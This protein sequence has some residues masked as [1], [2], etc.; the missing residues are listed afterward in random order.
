M[1]IGIKKETQLYLPI[2]AFFEELGYKVNAE[3]KDCDVVATKDDKVLIIELK[4]NFNISLLYQALDRQK[5]SGNVYIAIF[6]PKKD[7]ILKKSVY[8]AEKLGLGFIAVDF[9]REFMPVE[10]LACPN[11]DSKID[12]KRTSSLLKEIDQRFFEVNIAGVSG[13]VKKMTAYKEKAIKI[14]CA[15]D[16]A[17]ESSPKHLICSYKCSKDTQKILNSD[18][19]NW[20]DK[21]K[22]GVYCLSNNGKNFL[23]G[24]EYSDIINFYKDKIRG[25]D[26]V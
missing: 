3:V 22:R 19:Y 16:L 2:K 15:L 12:K 20:F 24:K 8:I 5:M 23:N 11:I 1:D 10:V 18:Y 13:S 17:K 21:V 7:S 26:N 9:E 6:H 25:N 14:A 4:Q